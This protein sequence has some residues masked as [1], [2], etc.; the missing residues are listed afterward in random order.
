[1]LGCKSHVVLVQYCDNLSCS[2]LSILLPHLCPLTT[3]SSSRDTESAI[4]IMLTLLSTPCHPSCQRDPP[5]SASL[6]QCLSLGALSLLTGSNI[7]CIDFFFFPL[8]HCKATIIVTLSHMLLLCNVG[9][10]NSDS[11][12]L[13][14]YTLTCP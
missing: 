7:S 14:A 3:P 2:S 12:N 6:P 11:L 4:K 9:L 10:F 8:G 13:D 1:M 5:S